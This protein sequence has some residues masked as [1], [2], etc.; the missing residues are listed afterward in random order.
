MLTL[1]DCIDLCELSE[2]EIKAIAEH[3]HVPE[4]VAVEIGEYLVETPGGEPRIKAMIRDDIEQALARRDFAHAA[5]LVGVLK[6]FIG[7]HP[8][9]PDQKNQ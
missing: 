3:E 6:H 1:R 8:S 2:E 7:S 5:K 9:Q 4:I